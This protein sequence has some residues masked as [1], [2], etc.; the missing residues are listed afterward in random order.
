[1]CENHF[2]PMLLNTAYGRHTVFVSIMG[3]QNAQRKE[4]TEWQSNYQKINMYSSKKHISC[5]FLFVSKSSVT[6]LLN[7]YQKSPVYVLLIS[8][9]VCE[10][11]LLL[12]ENTFYN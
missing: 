5:G 12:K 4:E 6:T 9:K 2:K 1:M 11:M 7:I 3:R 8:S 10:C